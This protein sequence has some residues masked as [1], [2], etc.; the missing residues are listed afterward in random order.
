MSQDILEIDCKAKENT[1]VPFKIIQNVKAVR[2]FWCPLPNESYAAELKAL[3]VNT[4]AVQELY[5]SQIKDEKL[6]R[7]KHFQELKITKLD[8]R[9]G[10]AN[11]IIPANDVL[12]HLTD[13]T[14]LN[15]QNVQLPLLSKESKVKY[16]TVDKGTVSR[17]NLR[18]CNELRQLNLIRTLPE[19]VPPN[20]LENCTKLETLRIKLLWKPMTQ[21]SLN[22][23][24]EGAKNLREL[25]LTSCELRSLPWDFLT[26]ARH[27]R[28]LI[29]KKNSLNGIVLQN[30]AMNSLKYLNLVDCHIN[31]L[32]VYTHFIIIIIFNFNS[33]TFA[34]YF[35]SMNIFIQGKL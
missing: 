25:D 12:D 29:L 30:I 9:N 15:L 26:Q 2:I 21:Q 28:R 27:L 19:S 8:I 32:Q 13:L 7:A 22:H 24:L 23:V 3:N 18:G 34:Y 6:V 33:L 20:W 4:T 14:V 10:F 31:V 17:N 16:I 35:K 5:L 11:D 1:T